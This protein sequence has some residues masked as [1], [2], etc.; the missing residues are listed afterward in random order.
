MANRIPP[1]LKWLID[2][3]ARLSA[4][5]KKT[6]ASIKVA[7]EMIRELKGIEQDLAA[8]DRAFTLHDIPVDIELIQPIRSHY[9][10]IKVPHGELTRAI[11]LCLKL[12]DGAPVRASQIAEFVASRFATLD[13]A[14]MNSV[15]LRRSVKYRLQNLQRDGAVMRH[16]PLKSCKDGLWSVAKGQFKAD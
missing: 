1:S 6:Q 8:I 10:R 9:F 11:L 7:R 12:A 5:I 15:D 2:K 13:S 16:H 14:P 4:E 3:R